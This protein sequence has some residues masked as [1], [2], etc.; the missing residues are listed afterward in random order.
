MFA[1]AVI[2]LPSRFTG[3]S[4]RVVHSG[5]E[6]VFDIASSSDFGTSLLAWYTDVMHEVKPVTTGY[7]LA[8]SYN[9]IQGPGIPR[10]SLPD[11]SAP[12]V[13]IRGVLRKWAKG[14]YD[15]QPEGISDYMAY[16]LGHQYSQHNLDLGALKGEDGY[17]VSHLRGIAEE[18]GFM[19]CLGNL[20]CH[21]SGQADG[22]SGGYNYNKRRRGWDYSDDEDEDDEDDCPGM[23]EVDEIEIDIDHLVDLDGRPLLSGGKL[24]AAAEQLIPED[25]FDDSITPDNEEYE[26]YQVSFICIPSECKTEN[27]SGKR[28]LYISF[29]TAERLPGLALVPRD[30]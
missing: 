14:G 21:K 11:V 26:G 29:N 15:D 23:G 18:L 7:R 10:P 3:G 12:L 24:D 13:R 16:V 8:L 6:Q 17:L 27:I 22:D 2:V 25:P 4:V 9:L 1:T 5:S 19:V 30:S 28:K 20:A